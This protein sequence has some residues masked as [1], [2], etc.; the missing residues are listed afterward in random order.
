LALTGLKMPP[1]QPRTRVG[2]ELRQLARAAHEEPAEASIQCGYSQALPAL[3]NDS[4]GRV[5]GNDDGERVGYV[6]F[7]LRCQ[8]EEEPG[9]ALLRRMYLDALGFSVAGWSDPGKRSLTIRPAQDPEGNLRLFSCS[10]DLDK[11]AITRLERYVETWNWEPDGRPVALDLSEI[12]VVNSQ[13]LAALTKHSD[14]LEAVGSPLA[15]VRVPPAVMIMIE[16]LELQDRLRIFETISEIDLAGC[17]SDLEP[18]HLTVSSS[19]RAQAREIRARPCDMELLRRYEEALEV[20][21]FDCGIQESMSRSYR[22]YLLRR[23][24]AAAVERAPEDT[25]LG[26]IRGDA[27]LLHFDRGY[28]KPHFDLG[29]SSACDDLRVLHLSGILDGSGRSLEAF[30]GFMALALA[31]DGP[32]IVFDLS[33]IKILNDTG[34]GSFVKLCDAT[35]RQQGICPIIGI[36]TKIALIF[37]MLGLDVLFDICSDLDDL[38]CRLRAL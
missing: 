18:A 2:E 28:P 35:R 21:S 36:P 14:A 23:A 24:L 11:S 19:L 10:G 20:L 16:M 17:G 4:P 7:A 37:E 8:L 12:R 30:Q 27:G 34:L 29:W 6:L 25:I 3:G 5:P 32:P 9:D 13:G 1:N 31:T 38:R 33:K 22:L 15:L 26:W